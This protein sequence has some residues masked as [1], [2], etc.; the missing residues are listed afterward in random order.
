VGD[1]L[2]PFL[3]NVIKMTERSLTPSPHRAQNLERGVFSSLSA[4]SA[5][6]QTVEERKQVQTIQTIQRS[7]INK[8]RSPAR[9]RTFV[10]KGEKSPEPQKRSPLRMQSRGREDSEAKLGIELEKT[11]EIIKTLKNQLEREKRTHLRLDAEVKEAKSAL[12][13]ESEKSEKAQ[14][15]LQSA[16]SN[17]T[18]LAAENERL[19]KEIKTE[20]EKCDILKEHLRGLGIVLVSVLGSIIRSENYEI[21]IFEREKA[22]VITRIKEL[23][24]QKLQEVANETNID[25]SRQINEVRG[26]LLTKSQRKQ[27]EKQKTLAETPDI[28][29]SVEYFQEKNEFSSSKGLLEVSNVLN[30]PEEVSFSEPRPAIALYDFEGERAEDLAFMTGDTIEV[31]EEC[32]SGWWVGRLNGKI[33]SFPYNF[34]EII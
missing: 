14:K 32:E 28:C 2:V 1:G 11:N 8:P 25:L 15:M 31:L 27:P 6:R 30:L 12:K 10:K 7:P 24:Y 19:E 34:V 26:W 16:I 13:L 22:L 33:G 17:N 9:I 18:V 21:S 29:Y 23:V 3:D 20:K 5:Y 4:L